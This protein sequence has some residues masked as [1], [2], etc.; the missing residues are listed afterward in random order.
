MAGNDSKNTYSYF[1]EI[2]TVKGSK[3]INLNVWNHL[4]VTKSNKIISF[5]YDG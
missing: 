4:T 1:E 3:S 2:C 5:Y